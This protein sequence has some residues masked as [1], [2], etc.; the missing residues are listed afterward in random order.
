MHIRLIFMVPVTILIDLLQ[1]KGLMGFK[2]AL[3]VKE[4]EHIHFICTC[5]LGA[6]S[7]IVGSSS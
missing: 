6:Q 3:M 7:Q 2:L 1:L 4:I 5:S